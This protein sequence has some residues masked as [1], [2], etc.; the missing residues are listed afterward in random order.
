MKEGEFCAS[1]LRLEGGKR[2]RQQ[3]GPAIPAYA[4]PQGWE[5][6]PAGAGKKTRKG[7]KTNALGA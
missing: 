1:Y 4:Q 5:R 2:A 6:F 7:G 3:R